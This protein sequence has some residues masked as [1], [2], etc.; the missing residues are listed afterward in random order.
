MSGHIPD[1]PG[2]LPLPFRQLHPDALK[3]AGAKGVSKAAPKAAPA[4]RKRRPGAGS[5][6]A[7]LLFEQAVVAGPDP[8]FAEDAKAL[9]EDPAVITRSQLVGTYIGQ[10]P[11]KTFAE[12]RAL[13]TELFN[14]KREKL[15]KLLKKE[16]VFMSALAEW[17][18]KTSTSNANISREL[19]PYV[20]KGM[21]HAYDFTAAP[22]EFVPAA[23]FL[24]TYEMKHHKIQVTPAL[25]AQPYKDFL[26]TLIHEEVHALQ[27]EMMLMLNVQKRGKVLSPP[28]RAI[29]QYWK[30]EEPKYRSALA[31]GSNMSPETKRRYQMIGQEYHAYTTAHYVSSKMTG[32][33]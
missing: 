31:A 13:M 15:V 17:N 2:G 12:Y 4:A 22:V 28:E 29:A 5:W 24:G 23:G 14:E 30:N 32:R 3:S 9:R 27:A 20:I 18:P 26:D 1:D 10:E 19:V 16:P 21:E 8:A 25:F 11:P 7:E 33:A 6:M